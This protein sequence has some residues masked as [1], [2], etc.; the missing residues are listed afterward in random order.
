MDVS[1]FGRSSGDRNRCRP[2]A[3][4]PVVPALSDET[5][6]ESEG[7]NRGE[8]RLIR[9]P[10]DPPPF[11]QGARRSTMYLLRCMVL[12]F[13]MLTQGRAHSVPCPGLSY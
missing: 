1:D 2:A 12:F 6:C 3:V 5:G 7:A 4:V 10:S 13:L 9:C 8:L 11:G